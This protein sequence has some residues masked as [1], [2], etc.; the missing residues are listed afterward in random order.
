MCSAYFPAPPISLS[1]PD[2]QGWLQRMQE[3]ER[4]VGITEAGIPQVSA[5][6]LSL[7]QRY[8]LGELTLE[9]LLV[10]QCQRLRV[11]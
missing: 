11:R 8:V 1:S 5:E 4:I 2:Q 7:W 6:T 9:Q 3:A 10:L